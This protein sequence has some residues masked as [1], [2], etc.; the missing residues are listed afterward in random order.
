MPKSQQSWVPSHSPSTQWKPWAADEAVLNEENQQKSTKKSACLKVVCYVNLAQLIVFF[1][2][3]IRRIWAAIKAGNSVLDHTANEGP[4]RIQYENLVPIYVFPEMK[5]CS[6]VIS[7]TETEAHGI[8][9]NLLAWIEAWL[10]GREQRVVLN[11]ECSEWTE[12]LS[13][14]PQG[15]LLGRHSSLYTSTT[16]TTRSA[17][18]S[19]SYLSLPSIPN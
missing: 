1:Q 8:G 15:S 13:G 7:K 10:T 11:G 4:V 6:F 3:K 17:C 19:P 18:S 16:W 5:L 2:D 9:G 12:V 14:V